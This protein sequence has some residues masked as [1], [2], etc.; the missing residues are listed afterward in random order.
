M[1]PRYSMWIIPTEFWLACGGRI[2]TRFELIITGGFGPFGES[3][4]ELE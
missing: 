3:L 1:I 2:D 4:Y